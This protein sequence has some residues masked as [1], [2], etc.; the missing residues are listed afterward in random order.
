MY[1]SLIF[2]LEFSLKI[3]VIEVP[4]YKVFRTYCQK[5]KK[6]IE[7]LTKRSLNF[8]LLFITTSTLRN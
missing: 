8:V 5:I 2:I 7:Y 6:E 1:N 3:V 4:K